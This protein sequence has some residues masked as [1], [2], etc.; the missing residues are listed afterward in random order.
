[1]AR[2]PLLPFKKL[3]DQHVSLYNTIFSEALVE[4]SKSDSV[5]GGENNI[6]KILCPILNRCC[7]KNSKSKNL[8]IRTPY[9]E[10]PI[11]PVSEED[12]KENE[13]HDDK[14]DF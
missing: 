2:R 8:D 3:W 5:S 4:L 7:Y 12:S 9:W 1:M 14:L 6:S 13:V 11:Q 10:A